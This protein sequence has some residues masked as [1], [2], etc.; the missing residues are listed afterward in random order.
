M[1]EALLLWG[2]FACIALQFIAF[3]GISVGAALLCGAVSVPREPAQARAGAWI[4]AVCILLLVALPWWP[5][6]DAWIDLARR[7]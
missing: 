4:L 3:L 7:P 5:V 1:N 6:W 2:K